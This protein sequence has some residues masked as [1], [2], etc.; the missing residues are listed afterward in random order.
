LLKRV[1][2]IADVIIEINCREHFSE[3][4]F[5][6]LPFEIKSKWYSGNCEIKTYYLE[7]LMHRLSFSTQIVSK[8]NSRN[9]PNQFPLSIQ[10]IQTKIKIAIC[11]NSFDSLD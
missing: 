4:D 11:K 10:S 2:I 8:R 9:V 7:E 3:L 1:Q 6:K 5:I